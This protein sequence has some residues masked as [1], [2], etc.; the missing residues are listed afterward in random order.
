[1]GDEARHNQQIDDD[2]HSKLLLV[3]FVDQPTNLLGRMWAAVATVFVFRKSR[4]SALSAGLA[5]LIATCVSFALCLVYLLSF[6]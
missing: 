3:R 1:M 2:R 4:A 6:P 5:R